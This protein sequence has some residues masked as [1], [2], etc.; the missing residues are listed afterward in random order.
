[1][2]DS[3]TTRQQPTPITTTLDRKTGDAFNALTPILVYV[4]SILALYIQENLNFSWQMGWP[5][6]WEYANGWEL[7]SNHCRWCPDDRCGVHHQSPIA[8][9]RNVIFEDN[10]LYN[11]CIDVHWMAY[12]DSTW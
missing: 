7:G 9:N 4:H 12:H 6:A 1:M 3:T 8:L 5:D 10:D 2:I 11:P